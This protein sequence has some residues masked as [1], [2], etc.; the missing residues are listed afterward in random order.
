MNIAP[1]IAFEC[2]GSRFLFDVEHVKTMTVRQCRLC[3]A[4]FNHVDVLPGTLPRCSNC[5][6]LQ[7]FARLALRKLPV[8]AKL[9]PLKPLIYPAL[10]LL[11]TMAFLLTT[12]FALVLVDGFLG[13]FS[14]RQ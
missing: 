5:S 10:V 9:S 6:R 12:Y 14:S 13:L 7:R 8:L 1:R 2:V 11:F 4:D 3:G